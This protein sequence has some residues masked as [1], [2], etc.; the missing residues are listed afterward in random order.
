MKAPVSPNNFVNPPVGNHVARCCRLEDLGTQ[1]TQYQG[2]AK[3]M[4]KIR[5][6]WELL[7]ESHVFDES[8]GPEH[9]MVG[10][11]FSF[12]MYKMS[13]L[14]KMIEGWLS[15]SLTD[16]QADGLDF[17]KMLGAACMVNMKESKDGKYVNVASVSALP[18][19]TVAPKGEIEQWAFDLEAPDWKIFERMGKKTREKIMASPEYVAMNAKP[20]DA[21]PDE[22]G[23]PFEVPDEPPAQEDRETPL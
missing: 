11:T 12:S 4:R 2:Q 20:R 14:R 23:Q 8:K 22:S 5:I 21:A 13:A 18:K 9:F 19:G 16:E 17:S 3:A 10:S 1:E 7:N 15:R 6:S